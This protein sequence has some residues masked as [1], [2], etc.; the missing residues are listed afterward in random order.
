[1]D[2]VRPSRRSTAKVDRNDVPMEG[3]PNVGNPPKVNSFFDEYDNWHSEKF[4][5][6]PY[7]GGKTTF[8]K[9]KG[10]S[11]ESIVTT[12]ASLQFT[13]KG[14]LDEDGK[15]ELVF[16]SPEPVV[17]QDTTPAATKV[18]EVNTP[19]ER[20]VQF[21]EHPRVRARSH[22]RRHKPRSTRRELKWF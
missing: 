5:N 11:V 14:K 22:E 3:G 15:L 7:G 19:Q 18:S 4:S 8:Q 16:C 13:M 21:A 9:T 2:N 17:T 6:T 12:L 10:H 1:M 20:I